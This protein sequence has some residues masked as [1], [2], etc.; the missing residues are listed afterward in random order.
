MGG[1]FL[2]LCGSAQF[3]DG[4]LAKTTKSATKYGAFYN[5]LADLVV[6]S[7]VMVS[8]IIYTYSVGYALM[9]MCLFLLVA[10]LLNNNIILLLN[11][12]KLAKKVEVIFYRPELVVLLCVGLILNQLPL[13]VAISLGLAL[14]TLAKIIYTIHRIYFPKHHELKSE[15]PAKKTA[16]K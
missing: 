6:D 1:L 11:T 4:L 12:L 15:K 10:V 14:A 13:F 3:M 7:L 8:L 16:D 5:T 2:A 9:L